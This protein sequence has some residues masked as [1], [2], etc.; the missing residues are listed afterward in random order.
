MGKD[1][2]GLRPGLL[3]IFTFTLGVPPPAMGLKLPGQRAKFQNARQ[4]GPEDTSISPVAP[5]SIPSA[6]YPTP[7]H[8][9]FRVLQSPDFTI[10]VPAGYVDVCKFFLLRAVPGLGF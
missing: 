10:R 5:N 1:F 2:P 3:L 7:Q 6:F 9:S 4:F 8:L